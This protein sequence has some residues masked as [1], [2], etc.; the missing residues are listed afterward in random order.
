MKKREVSMPEICLGEQKISAPAII[1]GVSGSGKSFLLANAKLPKDTLDL[2]TIG[3]KSNGK[4]LANT[5]RIGEADVA[6]GWCDNLREVAN[7]ILDQYEDGVKLNLY[8]I[9]PSPDIFRAANAAKAKDSS[10]ESIW[11]KDWL[12][13]SKYSDAQVKKFDDA[14]LS[15]IVKMLDPDH[16][17]IIRNVDAK[18][19][20]I[21]GWHES[22]GSPMP[23]HQHPDEKKEEVNDE[24]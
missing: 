20:I 5:E 12:A 19:P 7:T 11:K 9:S 4:W 10:S 15:M 2:D 14:K 1:T 6:V 18:S 21:K 8:W 3:S 13:K 22:S 16:L 17:V 23:D 24:R